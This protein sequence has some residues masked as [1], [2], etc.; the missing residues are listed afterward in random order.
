M[1][2]WRIHIL[3]V[4]LL[5]LQ[6]AASY[7]GTPILINDKFT[8]QE[9]ENTLNTSYNPAQQDFVREITLKNT[10]SSDKNLY[11]NFIN[12]TLDRIIIED[13]K[14]TAVLGDLIRYTVR[15]FKHYNHVYPFSL[16]SNET[17][18]IRYTIRRQWQPIN[19][20]INLSSENSFIR[21]TNHDNFLAGIFYGIFFIYLL[22]LICFYIFS[23]NKFFLIYFAIQFFTLIVFFQYSGNGYQYGWFYSAATQ[24][25]IAVV[26]VLGYLIAHISF[27]RLFFAVQFKNNFSGWMLKFIIAVLVLFGIFFLIQFYNQSYDNIQSNWNQRFIYAVFIFYGTMIVIL[28]VNT[29]IVARRREII[30]VTA[31]GILHFCNWLLFINNEYAMFPSFNGFSRFQLFSSN[32]FIPQNCY[33]ITMFEMFLVTVFM[34]VNYHNLIRQNNLSAKR[35]DFLQKRNINTFVLGQEEEREKITSSIETGISKDISK[36]KNDL[37]L[38][39]RHHPDT[40]IIPMVLDEMN[41]TL[42]DIK[43]I[44]S[45]YV[46]PDMQK[47]KLKE[48]ILTA[49]DKLF[50]TLEVNYDF[51]RIPENMLLNA[52]ANI[53]LYRI[54]Q[55]VSNNIIKHSGADMVN[56]SAINDN[57]SLQIKISDNGIGFSGMTA[58]KSGIGMMNIE[59]RINSLNGHFYV[60]SDEKIGSTIHLILLLKD[61]T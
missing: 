2:N 12:P 22:L 45:N 44:T 27:I 24:K 23:K 4:G 38:L 16:K 55:E 25:H 41:T 57:K 5:L 43:N 42:E 40:K 56:I 18:T 34:S 46:A 6:C 15:Q 36:I 61:I 7:G 19:F 1:L 30:W 32:L 14:Q 60:L 8:T 37:R 31:G 59:S 39:N 50:T 49:T 17:R 28:G 26:A 35:L 47:M 11:L 52:V 58:K 9:L 53:N 48:L 20:R 10:G 29:Y 13:N 33:Y 21:A 51:S 54:I 3:F